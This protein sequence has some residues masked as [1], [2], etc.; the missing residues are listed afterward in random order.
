[1][2]PVLMYLRDG[3]L[4]C[5]QKASTGATTEAANPVPKELEQKNEK[6]LLCPI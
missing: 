1:M 3:S 6:N 5:N 4:V 2:Q